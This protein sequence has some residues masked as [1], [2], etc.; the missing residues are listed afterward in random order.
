M[1]EELLLSVAYANSDA[2]E[3]HHVNV[4]AKR[5]YC[6]QPG[7]RATL[8]PDQRPL[9][10][11]PSYRGP[12]APEREAPPS[13]DPDVFCHLKQ[14]TDL[15]V[16]GAAHAPGGEARQ[17][18]VGVGVAASGSRPE[19]ARRAWRSLRVVGPRRL[20]VRG[21]AVVAF[22]APEPFDRVPVTYDRAYGGRDRWAHEEK[23]PDEEMAWLSKYSVHSFDELTHYNYPRN[24]CGSGYLVHASERALAE[25]E[26]PNVEDPARPLTPDMIVRGDAR[27]WPTAPLPA[28]FDWVEQSWFPRAAFV[29]GCPPHDCDPRTL[30]E[31]E[32][33]LVPRELVLDG[34]AATARLDAFSL[35]FFHGASRGLVLP[36]L[37]GDEVVVVAGMHRA[38]AEVAIELPGE[39]PRVVLEVRGTAKELVPALR[40]VVV[41]MDD[42]RIDVVWA[43][44]MPTDRAL[45]PDESKRIRHAVEWRLR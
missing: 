17:M 27:S 35:R 22:G 30:P 13:A 29:G 16:Q 40:T 12:S 25:L 41:R 2:P 15:V 10:F 32:S 8:A 36:T 42:E 20:V 21:G 45:L 23:H 34:Q 3:A 4:V 44:R 9:V 24:P 6:I 7:G 14:G 19:A 1:N 38:L 11:E 33:G 18:E 31:V 5:T 43:A 37:R 26:L 28:S 39:I